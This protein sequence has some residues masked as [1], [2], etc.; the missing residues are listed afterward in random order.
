LVRYNNLPRNFA[1]NLGVIPPFV[2]PTALI[3]LF[4]IIFFIFQYKGEWWLL[5]TLLSIISSPF[6]AVSFKDIYMADQLVSLAI[7]FYDIE[8]TFCYLFYDIQ[9]PLSQQT[10]TTSHT[11]VKPVLAILPSFWRFFQCLRRYYDTRDIF[12]LINATKYLSGILVTVFAFTKSFSTIW[13]VLWIVGI[14]VATV[15]SFIWDLKRDWS[16]AQYNV[17]Y[18]LVRNTKLYPQV[19]YYFGMITNCIMKVMWTLTIS[20]TVVEKLVNPELFNTF[21]AAVEIYRRGQWNIF[22]L[23]NEQINNIEKFH[24]LADVPLPLP[25]E[26]P[27]QA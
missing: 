20:P 23:E 24:V 4:V 6:S 25:T 27:W 2:F 10:C 7:V 14:T 15:F 9:F 18:T 1:K 26:D 8:Y 11:W 19:W 5:K 13:F 3:I 22:R 17:K 12:H 16:V 21:I